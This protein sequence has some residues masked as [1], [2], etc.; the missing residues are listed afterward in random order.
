M[1][2]WFG[3]LMTVLLFCVTMLVQAARISDIRSTK[4]NLSSNSSV[5]NVVRA[6][7][8]DEVCV[9][10]HTP[11]QRTSPPKGPLWNRAISGDVYSEHYTSTSIDAIDI[12]SSIGGSSKLCLSC[13]DG[14]IAVGAVNVLNSQENAN[15]N[16]QGTSGGFIPDTGTGS[17]RR[18]G[19]NLTNDHPISFTYNTALALADGELRP[20]IG[21]IGNRVAGVDPDPRV[22]LENDQVQC[23]S[24]HDP[25]IRDTDPSKIIKFLRLNRFQQSSPMGGG[26]DE[27]N[28][29]MCLACHE[30]MG[31]AW[32]L[33]SHAS[34][35]SADELY[36]DSAAT[37]RDFPTG[38]AVWEV[39]CL[40]CHDTHTVQG[41]RRLLREGTNPGAPYPKTSGASAIEE[42]CYQCHS[43]TGGTLSS[44][45]NGTQVADIKTDFTAIANRHMPIESADQPAATEVHDI[46]DADFTETRNNLGFGNLNNRHVECTDCHNPHRVLKNSQFN[47]AGANSTA[48]T[49]DH[50]SGHTNIA[51]GAL[52]GTSGVEPLYTSDAFGVNPISYSL[53]RGVGLNASIVHMDQGP[54]TREYQICLKCHS[55]Y[56]YGNF[57]PDLGSSGGST[58][59][60][61]NSP[62]LVDSYTNQAMEFHAP[63][64]HQ[65]EG[66][67]TT[68]PGVGTATRNYWTNNH[69]SWH[70]VINSTART[71]SQRGGM[72]STGFWEAPWDGAANI[73]TQTMYCSDCHGSN[74]ANGTVVPGGAQPDGNPWGPHGSSNDFILK[75]VWDTNT[76]SN[77]TGLCFKCH[78]YISY[79]TENGGGTSGFDDNGDKGPNL[80]AFHAKRIGKNLRCNWCHVA[81]PHGWKN[82]AFLVNLNDVGPECNM[83]NTGRT[84]HSSGEVMSMNNSGAVLNCPPYYVNA[85]LKVRN[86][87]TSGNWIDTD[88]GSAGNNGSGNGNQS[89]RD[90]MGDTCDNPP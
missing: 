7:T 45:G 31:L 29:I 51:S 52:S 41:A 73:G 59:A 6:T 71:P 37:L 53:Q 89:G 50:S 42:T 14:T 9:F 35:T 24:C 55:D 4:H 76:G 28:D 12:S 26:F 75:G 72:S 43:N 83:T 34:S 67:S 27:A 47:G 56:A 58:T 54:V 3:A 77:S 17:N 64:G 20:P 33:S 60:Y 30:K 1:R 16:M 82:K 69:R 68:N 36:T 8:E 13:H 18:L 65:G 90:W 2:C 21:H 48:A 57:P 66:T 23:I 86:F 15:I 46:L 38:K 81:V 61:V 88:C 11:H 78:D 22:P 63:A 49:H 85:K 10:C 19:I 39:A 62:N 32:A 74:T 79:A 87:R 80:H 25:H 84:L 70:P 40:N 44:Q 5:E